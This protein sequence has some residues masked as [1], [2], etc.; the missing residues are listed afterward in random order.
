MD[1]LRHLYGSF[2]ES[3]GNWVWFIGVFSIV[4]FIF[5]LLGSFWLILKLPAD[6]W[7]KTAQESES[8]LLKKI[9]KNMLGVLLITLGGLMLFLPGQGLLT[10]LLGFGISD[11][12]W[13][14]KVIVWLVGKKSI[15]K[16]LNGIRR[17]FNRPLFEFK[18]VPGTP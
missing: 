2:L 15:Q 12:P 7:T 18:K 8:H 11:L 1:R 6:H 4:F 10:I 17:K 5:G 13:K 9:L 16:A 14:K 3:S